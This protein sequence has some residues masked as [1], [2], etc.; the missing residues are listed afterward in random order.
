MTSHEFSPPRVFVSYSRSDGRECAEDFEEKIQKDELTSWRDLK[1]VVGG[2]DI[3]PQ[4]LRAI[5][6]SEHLVLILTECALHS[7]WVKREWTHARKHG[8]MVSPILADHSITRSDL[9]HWARRAEIYD[10]SEP[11]R[12]NKLVQ[13]LQGPGKTRRVS[14][15][16]GPSTANYVCRCKEYETL[17]QAVMENG[18]N[19]V[20]LTTALQGAGGYGK[21]TLANALCRDDDVQFE[22]S[23]GI[24][25]VDVGKECKS[26]L[27]QINDLL[28]KLNPDGKRTAF[29][30]I[31]IAAEH[32]GEILGEAR[33]LL[34]IDDV[35]RE[36]QLSPF[37]RGG[38]KCVR[39]VTTRIPASL[40]AGAIPVPVDEMQANES[41]A[42][43][44]WGLPHSDNACDSRLRQLAKRLEHWAQLLEMANGWLRSRVDRGERLGQAI[45][46][47]EKRLNMKGLTAFDPKK[48]EDRNKAVAACIE[49]S[50]EELDTEE[51]VRFTTLAIL[52]EDVVVP[53]TVPIRLWEQTEN[54][55]ELDSEDFLDRLA[56]LSLLQNYDLDSQTLHLHDNILWYLR[57]SI[58]KETLIEYHAAMVEALARQCNITG[59]WKTLPADNDYGWRFCLYHLRAAGQI[60]EA[61]ALLTDY[62][63]IK[64]KLEVRGSQELWESYRLYATDPDAQLI[65]R[66]LALSI[67]VLSER[68]NQLPLQLW[69]RLK[70]RSD[71]PKIQALVDHA[72]QDADF[73]P[74][75][76]WPGLTP[77]GAELVR[78]V[79][80]TESVSSAAFSPDGRLIVTASYD[81]TACI[82]ETD[83]G[84]LMAT[85][86]GHEGWVNCAAFSPDGR[87][88]LTVDNTT[89]HIRDTT[90]G[91]H[92]MAL[93]GHGHV[94][95]YAT[96]SSYGRRIVTASK[97]KTARIWETE[98]GRLITILRG[99]EAD[100]ISADFS[101]DGRQIVTASWDNTARVWDTDFDEGIAA[102]RGHERAIT[103]VAFSLDGRKIVTASRDKATRIWGASSG[104]LLGTLRGHEKGINSSV[105][106]P[107]GRLI[108]TASVDCTACIGDLDSNRVIT[109]LRGHT[110]QAL[111]VDFSPT[112]S[113]WIVTASADT[114]ARIWDTDTGE[115][116]RTLCGHEDWICCVAFFPDGKRILTASDDKT[117]RIWDADSGKQI[118]ILLGHEDWIR[119]AS[120]SPDGKWIVTTSKDA[121]ARIWNADSCEH[122]TTLRGHADW[123]CSA[124][125]SPD[126]RRIITTSMDTTA[127]IWEADTGEQMTILR[128]HEGSVFRAAFFLDGTRIV[129]VSGDKTARIWET[130][131]GEELACIVLDAVPSKLDI[132]NNAIALGDGLGR[133][134]IFDYD[135]DLLNN[136]G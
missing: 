7:D 81:E 53:L 60:A 40:P 72:A 31:N 50:L 75:P 62:A 98:S 91:E 90:T 126:G 105:F 10:L 103:S 134:H 58:S 59:D 51:R 18:D 79:G 36:G 80:H 92:L 89:I 74:K 99:H 131:T 34:V 100:V 87:R 28:A 71:A 108:A 33:I 115:H 136:K 125:F 54:L 119:V 129:T 130:D 8:V 96:F 15:M 37:L 73:Y 70:E 94:I 63:W 64:R 123:V 83:S 68:P 12:W 85:L 4:V 39:L 102:L 52:P 38:P 67:P 114:T 23:D 2:E 86:R 121:T 19:V 45:E 56:A 78:L 26:V 14:Y 124:A 112:N 49:A 118:M 104:E 82:W 109:T 42:L 110:H 27:P 30:D 76:R 106:S 35:W 1:S 55:D 127:R 77:P 107:D 69:G 24:L 17:K 3:R 5:E 113:R 48:P 41:L 22:F 13:V 43:L 32:L 57:D 11:E 47:F 44:Q 97:D 120:F 117:I 46:N 93:S 132:Y 84:E 6:E 20:G 101:P 66:A 61:D 116:L 16:T 111:S 29:E 133:I 135:P 25:R 21:T 128:G 65:G 9:P 122:V 88:I 95:N